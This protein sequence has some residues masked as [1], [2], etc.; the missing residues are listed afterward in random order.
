MIEEEAR[1]KEMHNTLESLHN[2][3]KALFFALQFMKD[4]F[5]IQ[6]QTL[7]EKLNSSNYLVELQKHGVLDTNKK[8][9][10]LVP[11]IID[12][13][14]KIKGAQGTY[15]LKWNE[16]REE[17]AKLQSQ[18]IKTMKI[19]MRQSVFNEIMK[20]L[21]TLDDKTQLALYTVSHKIAASSLSQKDAQGYF[22]IISA[23]QD[24]GKI[25][26]IIQQLAVRLITIE[27]GSKSP[28]TITHKVHTTNVETNEIE[29]LD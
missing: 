8:I 7:N 14:F 22:K 5:Q 15:F 28:T 12:A 27:S 2:N 10:P 24:L 21:N 6:S 9:N 3:E 1:L 20:Y 19:K 25:P 4:K 13:A 17:I 29:L 16:W 23:N 11:L 26:V 18:D